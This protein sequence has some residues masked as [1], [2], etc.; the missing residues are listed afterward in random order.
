[1]KW[2]VDSKPCGCG[3]VWVAQP[4]NEEE[5]DAGGTYVMQYCY[6]CHPHQVRFS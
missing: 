4:Y 6:K 1:M 5:T 2:G 3:R